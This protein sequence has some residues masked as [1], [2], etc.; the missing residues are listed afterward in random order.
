MLIHFF[1][2]SRLNIDSE[3]FDILS[4][5]TPNSCLTNLA[6][7]I[8]A[9]RTTP[10]K[11]HITTKDFLTLTSDCRKSVCQK[12]KILFEYL[13][14]LV[15]N[16][17][18][19]I[20]SDFVKF[21]YDKKNYFDP[22]LGTTMLNPYNFWI[23]ENVTILP[24]TILNA[25]DG[26]I[27]IDD[28]V[29]IFPNSVIIGPTYIGKNSIIKSQ[30]KIYEGTT[31][32]KFCKVG[33]EV[34][35]TIIQG[36]SNKQHDGFLGHSYIGEWVNIGAGTDN[37]DLK[38]TYGNIKTYFYPK[39]EKIDTKLQ[40]FGCVIADYTRVGIG[41]SI[42]TGANIGLGCNLYGHNLIKDYIPPFSFGQANELSNYQI[43]KLLNTISLMK[44]R[45]KLSLSNVE[46]NLIKKLHNK[47]VSQ[48]SKSKTF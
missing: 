20:E 25:Q 6:E 35:E 27:V 36:Y 12:P 18:K 32:G 37:S 45:R 23:G 39:E 11:G 29:K 7:D 22:Q 47:Y 34:E 15:E 16:N 8:V 30:A 17:N 10:E 28:N 21:F 33:G 43:D 31:I 1:V 41:V 14:D 38:N 5:I 4:N 13:W 44:K 9:F 24:G 19:L 3:I 48:N 42:N 2:N 46:I 40:F 26:P